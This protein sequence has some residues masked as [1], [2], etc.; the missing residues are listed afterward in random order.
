MFERVGPNEAK[1]DSGFS[2]RR[3][4]RNDL[5]YTDQ[6]HRLVVEV[7]PGDGLAVYMSQVTAW[8]EPSDESISTEKKIEIRENIASALT[9]LGIRHVMR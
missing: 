2:V 3:S 8:A 7:E 6:G 4:G 5:I 1:S 9:Y